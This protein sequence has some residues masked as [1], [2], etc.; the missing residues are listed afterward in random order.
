M[1]KDNKIC[2]NSQ[3]IIT[4]KLRRN[5]VDRVGKDCTIIKERILKAIKE[6]TGTEKRK[7]KRGNSG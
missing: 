3:D 7:E 4:E 5:H 1:S 2:E 6:H